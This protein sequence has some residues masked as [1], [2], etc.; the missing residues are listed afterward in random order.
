M[1]RT[2]QD[3]HGTGGRHAHLDR[4]AGM[5]DAELLEGEAHRR[6]HHRARRLLATLHGITPRT[7]RH[8]P[9]TGVNPSFRHAPI[10]RPD[11]I[12]AWGRI[13]TA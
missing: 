13:P 1:R 10:L 8:H 11:H 7:Q 4:A 12:A 2:R 5:R 9:L 6:Q 3:L